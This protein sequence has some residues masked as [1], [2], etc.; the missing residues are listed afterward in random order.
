MHGFHNELIKYSGT[1]FKKEALNVLNNIWKQDILLNEYK[2][3]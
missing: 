3:I 1:A 2:R